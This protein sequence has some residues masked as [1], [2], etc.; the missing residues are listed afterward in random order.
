MSKKKGKE[1][2]Q[3]EINKKF[4]TGYVVLDS[5]G[6]VRGTMTIAHDC[7]NVWNCTPRSINDSKRT[8]SSFCP[9]CAKTEIDNIKREKAILNTIS[10]W[11]KK[12]KMSDNIELV[13]V[14]I[15]EKRTKNLIFN[16]CQ[17]NNKF[18]YSIKRV[19]PVVECRNCNSLIE[20]L[21]RSLSDDLEIIDYNNSDKPQITIKH[22][23]PKCEYA[24]FTTRLDIYTSKPPRCYVCDRMNAE[25]LSKPVREISDYLDLLGI[26]YKREVTLDGCINARTGYPLRFDFQI[27]TPQGLKY[28]EY[29]GE[30]HF[31]QVLGWEDVELNKYRDSLK[32]DYCK[33]YKIPL[34]RIAYTQYNNM[35][36]MIDS[37]I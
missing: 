15:N 20:R 12:L 33:K 28:I 29:D 37:F 18:R 24:E 2:F 26:K 32:N 30:Q 3:H 23:N 27:E 1:D 31:K 16:C 19:P 10:T 34:L 4:G 8:S 35:F 25:P 11:S 7:G 9:L 14:S 36:D 17:C 13:D 21:R 5:I 22:N 6:G